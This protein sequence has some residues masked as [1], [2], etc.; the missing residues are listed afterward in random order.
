[1]KRYQRQLLLSECGAE[2]Q[3]SLQHSRVLII[4]AGGLGTAVAQYLGAAG[5]GTLMVVDGD[6][7]QETN[8]HRQVLFRSEDVGQNKAQVLAERL[9]SQNKEL[10]IE[11][12][13]RFLDKAMALQIFETVSL[14]VD[15]TD[16]FQTKFLIND[17]AC[18]YSKPVVFAAISRFE[19]QLSVLAKPRS[20]LSMF[21]AHTA[22]K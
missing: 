21:L 8:L 7:V 11:A 9:R 2:G 18:L 17:V 19:G 22:S 1:M 10:T 6:V 14:I 12:I 15:G 4:G 5:I 16:N 13:P 20:L 3:L